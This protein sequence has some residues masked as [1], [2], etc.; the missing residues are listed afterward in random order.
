MSDTCSN[1]SHSVKKSRDRAREN[2]RATGRD[3]NILGSTG[4][5]DTRHSLCLIS[6]HDCFGG[7]YRGRFTL[8]LRNPDR[9]APSP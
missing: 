7:K 5:L 2:R 8:F 1:F 4:E 3:R 6:W 9:L